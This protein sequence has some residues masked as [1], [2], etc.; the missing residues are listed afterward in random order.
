M[1]DLFKK[2]KPEVIILIGPQG[3]G[4]GTQGKK[5]S[6]EFGYYY[7]ETGAIL[8]EEVEKQTVLGKKIASAIKQGHLLPDEI[9][10][11]LLMEKLPTQKHPKIIFDG[12]T[13]KLHQ[14]KFLLDF[15][16]KQQYKK[17]A[18]VVIDIPKAESIR[19]LAGRAKIEGR[20]D[21]TPGAI[22]IRLMEYER[23]TVPVITFLKQTMPVYHVNGMGAPEEVYKQMKQI[24]K[25]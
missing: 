19:R 13:R 6:Q 9:I 2:Q 24:L 17:I 14:T 8:R 25:L 16:Q 15:L 18:A 1:F 20:K 3:S 23:E 21:D 10:I 12:V 7:W 11:H 4:K 5:L 22:E